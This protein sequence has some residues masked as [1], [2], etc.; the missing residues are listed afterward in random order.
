VSPCLSSL[1]AWLSP[2]QCIALSLIA[3]PPLC[4]VCVWGLVIDGLLAS[5]SVGVGYAGDRGC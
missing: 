5:L 3:S 1:L 4:F 2:S